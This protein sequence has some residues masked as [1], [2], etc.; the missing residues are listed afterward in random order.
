MSEQP[1]EYGS[2]RPTPPEDETARVHCVD[3]T[4]VAGAHAGSAG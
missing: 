3:I 4:N 1:S 2:K